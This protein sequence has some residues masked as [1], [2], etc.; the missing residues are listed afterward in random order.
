MSSTPTVSVEAA[1]LAHILAMIWPLADR[2]DDGG[3]DAVHLRVVDGTLIACATDRYVVGWARCF[4]SPTEVTWDVLISRKKA[5]KMAKRLSDLYAYSGHRATL[6]LVGPDQDTLLVH[7]LARTWEVR[8]RPLSRWPR[9]LLARTASLVLEP[10]LWQEPGFTVDGPLFARLTS[11]PA[12]SPFIVTPV[13]M[14]TGGPL[15]RVT[16][17]DFIGAYVGR[18]LHRSPL[19][20][21]DPQRTYWEDLIPVA[22]WTPIL[23][24]PE[25]ACSRLVEAMAFHHV[26]RPAQGGGD[27]R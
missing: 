14:Q 25:S 5:R 8:A 11:L 4:C 21:G 16:A 17:D 27:D 7:T 6:S 2:A 18:T 9:G 3:L 19:T 15:I 12:T 23:T 20:A 13:V 10:I 24:E 22:D 26:D 1:A